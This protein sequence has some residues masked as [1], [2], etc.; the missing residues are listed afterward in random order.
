MA[1]AFLWQLCC[2]QSDKKKKKSLSLMP[3]PGFTPQN[4]NFGEY[5]SHF[6]RMLHKLVHAGDSS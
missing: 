2:K 4:I 5:F 6:K 1:Y 3:F